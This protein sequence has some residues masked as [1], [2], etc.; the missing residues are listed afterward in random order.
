MTNNDTIVQLALE[1]NEGCWNTYASDAYVCIRPAVNY[2]HQANFRTGIGPEIFAYASAD[3]NF[4]GNDNPT[5]DEIA[6]YNEHG[7]YITC[8]VYVQR[9]EVLESNFYAWRVTGDP[10]YLDRAR[11]AAHSF[12]KY[13]STPTGFAGIYDVNNR[14]TM[15]INETESFWFAEVLKYL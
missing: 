1:L 8:P 5:P 3:G 7:F 12:I 4:T 9:P 6:F 15:K 10:K 14:A 13:L 11:S 2:T